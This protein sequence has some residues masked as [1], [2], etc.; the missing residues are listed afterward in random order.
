MR[1]VRLQ[2]VSILI[3]TVCFFLTG[4]VS[5]PAPVQD[6]GGRTT[7]LNDHLTNFDTG[8]WS[9]ADWTNGSMF[10]CGWLPDHVTLDGISA[11]T[12]TLDKTPSHGK[13]YSSGEYRTNETFGYGYFEV[14]MKAAKA[15]GIVSSFFLYTGKPWD[16]IDIEFLGKDTTKVQFN[17]YVNGIGGHEY[18]QDLGFDASSASH[19]YAIEWRNGFIK[20]YV[21]GSLTH[22]VNAGSRPAHAMQIMMNLWP[23]TG[24]DGWLNAFTYS[25]PLTATYDYVHYTP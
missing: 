16:E 20:W 6:P 21:D 25:A 19:I 4:C 10:N 3:L 11:M 15:N 12:I 5:G 8:T 9:K 14:S 18:L 24:V 2:A 17:Y 13:V 7:E 1:I 23:G 22:T